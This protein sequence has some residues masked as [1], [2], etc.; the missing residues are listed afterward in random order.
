MHVLKQADLDPAQRR[1]G[2]EERRVEPRKAIN[3]DVELSVRRRQLDGSHSDER[4]EARTH[5]L[6]EGGCLV[7]VQEPI[8]PGSLCHVVFPALSPEDSVLT[9]VGRV[10][11]CDFDYG[12]WLLGIEFEDAVFRAA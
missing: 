3:L 1:K 4:I 12:A 7:E 11:R 5:N 2:D 6:S 9:L 8:S 10:K